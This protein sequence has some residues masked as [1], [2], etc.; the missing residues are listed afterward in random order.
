LSSNYNDVTNFF[1]TG[2]GSFGDNFTSVM[3]TLGNN[4]PDGE[5]HLDLQQNSSQES[6]LN[7]DISNENSRISAEQTTLTTE[8]NAANFTLQQIPSQ[9]NEVNEL[10]SAITGFN[11]NPNG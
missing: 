10:Y 3:N 7:T 8:L 6:T 9:L 1:E 2:S 4:A 11:Q 5:I